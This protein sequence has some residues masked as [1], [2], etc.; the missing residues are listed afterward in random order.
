MLDFSSVLLLKT[1][2]YL[3]NQH[4]YSEIHKHKNILEFDHYF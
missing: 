4:S 3:D 1:K 2:R